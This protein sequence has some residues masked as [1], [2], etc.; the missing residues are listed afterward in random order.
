MVVATVNSRGLLSTLSLKIVHS[1]NNL[2]LEPKRARKR[3]LIKAKQR[4]FEYCSIFISE[5]IVTCEEFIVSWHSKLQRHGW[6][7]I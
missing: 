2:D 6:I 3:A 7:E 1:R 4:K 5:I